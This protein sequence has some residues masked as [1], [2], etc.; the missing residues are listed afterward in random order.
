MAYDDVIGV[1]DVKTA[2]RRFTG[3]RGTSGP[4]LAMNSK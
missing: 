1:A 4:R 2:A 3:W